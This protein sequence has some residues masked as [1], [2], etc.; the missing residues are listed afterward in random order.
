MQ[1]VMVED[2]IKLFEH[3]DYEDRILETLN[4]EIRAEREEQAIL[5]KQ[6]EYMKQLKL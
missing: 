1:E 3:R 4:R 2:F 5:T 6:R